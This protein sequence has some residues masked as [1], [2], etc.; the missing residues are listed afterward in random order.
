MRVWYGNL[1]GGMVAFVLTGVLS[2]SIV[3]CD[4]PD[5]M[6]IAPPGAQIPRESPDTDAAQ[7][8]GETAAPT[9]KSEAASNKVVDYTPAPPTAKGETKST[10]RGV[11]YETI[12]EGSGPELKPNQTAQFLYVGKL[13]ENGKIFDDHRKGNPMVFS[14]SKQVIEGW[15]EALPGMK[16]GETRKLTIPPELG[17]GPK[18]HPPEI[19][20]NA[21]LEFEVELV[22]IL[23]GLSPPPAK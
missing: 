10:K 12:K 23:E 1:G 16:T 15:Q 5:I 14:T 8:Q 4:A 13:A 2:L 17:Y 9:I 22:K 18:G 6:P 11:K 3:G 19:P 21:T 20:P 7:A